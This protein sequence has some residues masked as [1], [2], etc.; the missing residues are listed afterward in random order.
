[1]SYKEG[2]INIKTKIESNKSCDDILAYSMKLAL[3]NELLKLKK[4]TEKEQ[5]LIKAKLKLEHKIV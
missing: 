3:L 2:E 4:I 1:M 5:S